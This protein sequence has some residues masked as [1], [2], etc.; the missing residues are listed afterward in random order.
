MVYL[1]ETMQE[2]KTP[3]KVKV[4]NSRQLMEHNIVGSNFKLC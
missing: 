1:V 2:V 4:R 3:P